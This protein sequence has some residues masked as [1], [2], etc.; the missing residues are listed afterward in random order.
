M[1]E[2]PLTVTANSVSFAL[3][4]FN[5]PRTGFNTSGGERVTILQRDSV[6]V[7]HAKLALAHIQIAPLPKTGVAPGVVT[8]AFLTGMQS[9]VEGSIQ[10]YQNIAAASGGTVDVTNVVN[11]L[12]SADAYFQQE[13]DAI[14]PVIAGQV[15]QILIGQTSK[16]IPIVVNQAALAV[17][18]R[19][20]TAAFAQIGTS[21]SSTGALRAMSIRPDAV[22]AAQDDDL[23]LFNKTTQG[24]LN[25][26]QNVFTTA[27]TKTADIFKSVASSSEAKAGIALFTLGVAAGVITG[28][29]A[30]AAA[31]AGATYL[32][33]TT[34]IPAISAFYTANAG[35]AAGVEGQTSEDFVKS[36]EPLGQ[37]YGDLIAKE[38]EGLF[39][40]KFG[41]S[42]AQKFPKIADT[43]DIKSKFDKLANLTDPK[44]SIFQIAQNWN[45]ANKGGITPPSQSATIAVNP[46]SLNLTVMP[47][48]TNVSS[49]SFTVTN[50]GP[51]TSTIHYVVSKD[52]LAPFP[53]TVNTTNTTLSGGSSSSVTITID[54]RGLTEGTYNSFVSVADPLSSNKRVN[55]PITVKVSKQ[56]NTGAYSGSYSLSVA[57]GQDMGNFTGTMTMTIDSVAPD[58][59]TGNV[60]AKGTMQLSDVNGQSVTAHFAGSPPDASGQFSP[61]FTD[62]PFSGS[63]FVG[64]VSGNSI[65]GQFVGIVSG[66][67]NISG[68]TFPTG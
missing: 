46:S 63:G 1:F 14:A 48:A 57:V 39:E 37:A 68:G 27:F 41:D 23:A 13:K 36:L 4:F 58:P 25:D 53:I 62:G 6:G 8:R 2:I 40:E 22:Q 38:A 17:S 18:D 24:V 19:I 29:V 66:N 3:P 51:A 61:F 49:L 44:N 64:Q 7:L 21:T 9:I 67:F 45:K 43:L 60:I 5:A 42:L 12:Q 32:T 10:A 54:T 28:P 33:V 35:R 50:S 20:I 11:A 15:S 26:Y 59:T 47:N 34:F 65:T 52:P 16:G 56:Q 55:V 31:V 30:A